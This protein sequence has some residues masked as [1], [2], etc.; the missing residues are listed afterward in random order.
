MEGNF[1]GLDMWLTRSGFDPVR[2][3]G[4]PAEALP[5]ETAPEAG[6]WRE[7]ASNLRS[8]QKP[9]RLV[10]FDVAKADESCT[11][12][13]ATPPASGT[14]L[15]AGAPACNFGAATIPGAA[16]FSPPS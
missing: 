1:D 8:I 11:G 2:L 16:D 7:L 10:Q 15:A 5:P 12:L 14:D 13:R 6:A 3:A 9:E 4:F